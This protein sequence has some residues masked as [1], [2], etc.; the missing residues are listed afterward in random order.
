MHLI[1]SAKNHCWPILIYRRV[2]LTTVLSGR[3]MCYERIQLWLLLS[4]FQF[5]TRGHQYFIFPSGL[6]LELNH[7]IWE[8]YFKSTGLQSLCL[9]WVK[10]WK[11]H[12]HNLKFDCMQFI[13]IEENTNGSSLG[14]VHW[15]KNKRLRGTCYEVSIGN[16]MCTCV[17]KH[18]INI[19]E[20]V[21]HRTSLC[22]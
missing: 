3:C 4:V 19:R 5:T 8:L 10:Y 9:F 7:W 15:I 13:S 16:Q 20:L 2:I 11:Y 1:E 6:I 12:F 18:C 14:N 21:A 17:C 22:K